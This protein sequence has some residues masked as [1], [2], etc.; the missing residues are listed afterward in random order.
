MAGI[1]KT[2][3]RLWSSLAVMRGSVG[4]SSLHFCVPTILWLWGLSKDNSRVASLSAVVGHIRLAFSTCE[5]ECF[6]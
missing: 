5:N 4:L 2:D 3:P 1:R 6:V